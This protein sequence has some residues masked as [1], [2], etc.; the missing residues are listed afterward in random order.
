MEDLSCCNAHSCLATVP[1]TLHSWLSEELTGRSSTAALLSTESNQEERCKQVD[2]RS[3]SK[4][5]TRQARNA[6]PARCI[7]TNPQDCENFSV[8]SL[9]HLCHIRSSCFA[10]TSKSVCALQFDHSPDEA[11]SATRCKLPSYSKGLLLCL[12]EP[13]SQFCC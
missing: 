13:L 8:A 4:N 6:M 1:Q 5:T 3:S 7:T 10:V 11:C 9:T 2:P 12:T